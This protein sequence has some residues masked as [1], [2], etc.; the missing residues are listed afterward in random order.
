MQKLSGQSGTLDRNLEL[1]AYRRPLK[2]VVNE[3][4]CKKIRKDKGT[5]KEKILKN[6]NIQ[7]WNG[8]GRC[9]EYRHR[10]DIERVK[11]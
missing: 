8:G 6:I 3:I 4:A 1:S 11:K 9:I 5:Y 2:L 10:N 7:I